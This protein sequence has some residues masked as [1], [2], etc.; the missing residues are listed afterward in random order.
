MHLV[1]LLAL[2][3]AALGVP[4]AG[5]LASPAFG[6]PSAAAGAWVPRPADYPAVVTQRDLAIPMSDGVVLRGDLTL[7]ADSSGRPVPGRFP[8]VVTITAYNKSLLGSVA[9]GLGGGDSAYLVQRGYAQLTVDAR[10][11]GSSEGQWCAFCT[12]ENTD[13]TEILTWAASAERPWSNGS[14]AMTGPSYMGIS[15]L[16][17]AAGDPPGLKAIFPQVPAA[18]VYRD[19]VASGGQIDVGFI[20]LWIGLVT[21]TGIVPPAVTATDPPSGL[22]AFVQH[23]TAALTFSAP[24]MLSALGGAET[25]FDGDFYRQRSPIE[26]V[27]R[28]DV[29]TFLV[30]GEHDL[31]QRGTPMIFDRLQARGVPVKMIIGPWDH[32]AGSSG[33]ELGEAGHGSLS[34]LQLRWFDHHVKGLPDPGLSA[35]APITYYEQGTGAWRTANKWVDHSDVQATVLPLSGRATPGSPGALGATPSQPSVSPVLPIPV[36]GLC[37]RSANQWTA[38][39]PAQLQLLTAACFDDNRINDATATVF[40]TAPLTKELPI[41]GPINARLFVESTSGDG[42]LSVSVSDVAPDGSVSRLTGGWQVIGFRELDRG[43]SLTLDGEVLQPFH[44]FTRA[45]Y[46]PARSGEVVPV[47]VEVFPTG[48]SIQPGHKLRLSVHA[49]DVPHLLPT[50]PQLPGALTLMEIHAS[51]AHPSALVLPTRT[52][53]RTPDLGPAGP[54]RTPPAAQPTGTAT[55]TPSTSAP[56]RAAVRVDVRG[57]RAVVRVPGASDGTLRV[58]LDG[59]QYAVRRFT[60]PR[61]VVRLPRLAHGRHVLTVRY[62]GSAMVLPASARRTFRVR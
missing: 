3:L 38:G 27:D 39:L 18:D 43:R 61:T 5:P 46:S 55:V 34:E 47:D 32:L 29:P 26:V 23:L 6:T 52:R 15:Q 13:A 4:V 49:F 25:A 31:F 24:V 19:V 30:A 58:R 1:T 35:I 40:E 48:A 56:L 45:S 10:G 51:P 57:R 59:R 44:P 7:P 21:M 20:P 2:L 42:M 50:L 16:F 33:A 41:L 36:A 17:A 8:V 14:T 37:S 53:A 12:R 62:T 9:G 54:V 28:I 22:A 11:T 60:A